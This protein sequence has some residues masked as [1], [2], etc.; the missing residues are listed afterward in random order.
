MFGAK[1]L[2]CLLI[3]AIKTEKCN[4]PKNGCYAII[5][6]C[7]RHPAGSAVCARETEA[8][9][10]ALGAQ[11]ETQS[12]AV[13]DGDVTPFHGLPLSLHPI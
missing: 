9:T 10:S 5:F 13:G 11:I 4:Q 3:N 12:A 8:D 1:K 2:Y 6:S 7:F